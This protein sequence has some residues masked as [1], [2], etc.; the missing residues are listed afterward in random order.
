MWDLVMR[1]KGFT[2]WIFFNFKQKSKLSLY[3]LIGDF[4]MIWKLIKDSKSD[5]VFSASFD[6]DIDT[7]YI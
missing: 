6:W 3:S 7:Y 4:F 5:V 1:E 2:P